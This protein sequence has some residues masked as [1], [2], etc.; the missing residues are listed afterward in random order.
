ML[1][2]VL[3]AAAQE[4]P[5]LDRQLDKC[6]GGKCPNAL[7][8]PIRS[9]AMQYRR[10]GNTG[11]WVSAL[12]YGAWVTFGSQIGDDEA[13]DIM[14]SCIELGINTF[15]NAEVYEAGQVCQALST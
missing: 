12:S 9:D 8:R 7:Q 10:L 15:D 1:A 4:A 3:I 13:Y 5:D 11:L 2:G 14:K 6:Q